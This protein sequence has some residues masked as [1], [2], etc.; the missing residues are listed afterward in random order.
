MRD[1]LHLAF[2]GYGNAVHLQGV[3]VVLDGL[4]FAILDLHNDR[5][6]VDEH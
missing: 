4:D 2:P 1:D 3:G 6:Q 5:L